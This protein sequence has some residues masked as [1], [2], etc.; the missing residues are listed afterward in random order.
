MNKLLWI[1]LAILALNCN[2]SIQKFSRD[3]N[4]NNKWEDYYKKLSMYIEREEFH[5][6][7]DIRH[8]FIELSFEIDEGKGLYSSRAFTL[9]SL[10]Y[11]QR[12]NI[13]QA[14]RYLESAIEI[15]TDVSNQSEEMSKLFGELAELYK[16]NGDYELSLNNYKKSINILEKGKG[17]L[18]NLANLYQE[19]G[20]MHFYLG[21][22]SETINYAQK[23]VYYF[24][25]L[26]ENNTSNLIN[27]YELISSAYFYNNLY[28]ESIKYLEKTIDLVKNDLFDL[29]MVYYRIGL[30]Y[31]ESKNYQQAL[32]Y[33]SKSEDLFKELNDTHE[34][35]KL[36]SKIASIYQIIGKYDRA[37]EILNT[38]FS[39]QNQSQNN[40]TIDFAELN[41]KKSQIYQ[42]K[43]QI[44]NAFHSLRETIRLDK[45]VFGEISSRVSEDYCEL[46]N[47]YQEH[48]DFNKADEHY[49]KSIDIYTKIEETDDDDHFIDCLYSY[50]KLAKKQNKVNHEIELLQ[51][52]V[53]HITHRTKKYSLDR[54]LFLKK[55]NSIIYDLIQLYT[56]KK[57][58]SNAFQIIEL[59]RDL[60]LSDHL[61]MKNLMVLS[62]IPREE[63]N[64]YIYKYNKWLS[65]QY[66]K[67][68]RS[69][70]KNLLETIKFNS[71]NRDTII[72]GELFNLKNFIESKEKMLTEKY[73][74]FRNYLRSRN[75]TIVEIQKH[76]SS[77]TLYLEFSLNN[78]DGEEYFQAFAIYQSEYKSTFIKTD[79]QLMAKIY[80]IFK[81]YS[82]VED[83][84][85]FF[86]LKDYPDQFLLARLDE[87]DKDQK[88]CNIKYNSTKNGITI[89][90]EKVL[91][92]V[93]G[94]ANQKKIK[95]IIINDQKYLF[96]IL[97]K[98]YIKKG[99][100][101]I[102]ISPDSELNLLP[103]NVLMNENGKEII[104]DYTVTMVFSGYVWTELNKLPDY[105]F[106]K[107][108]LAIGNAIYE[109]DNYDRNKKWATLEDQGPCTGE[110]DL[111]NLP[112]TEL[113]I[114]S[115][116]SI[117]QKNRT[118]NGLEA[119]KDEILKILQEQNNKYRIIH[120]A[121]HGI[122]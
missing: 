33:F 92:K 85:R 110:N 45:E 79:H 64:Q 13:P 93:S 102:I 90:E 117:F 114:E 105:S 109:S 112:S 16:L 95:E 70:D 14:I 12:K 17:N 55:Y 26:K 122:Y 84:R 63:I 20:T 31:L 60:N 47:L 83:N 94:I 104:D 36:L 80:N 103:F 29:A 101:K 81:Y 97:I 42:S 62:E 6:A 88:I 48:N 82:K 34:Q 3:E 108:L 106:S 59:V 57:L 100:R 113:E 58:M 68:L 35:I 78:R 87:C 53:D 37:L 51:K 39:L 4:K 76:L 52:A 71:N 119:N 18:F 21:L 73:P 98:P 44:E 56:D 38:S 49:S 8:A 72:N 67:R 15:N 116:T 77:D 32:V 75:N 2:L 28:E 11:K 41:R 40:S 25:E 69:K 115:I 91:E 5:S 19:I 111:K 107:D 7:D 9:L 27:L 86:I 1:L 118:L 22:F 30:V 120:F 50:S 46:G 54:Y 23:S 65:L 74:K 121:T 61:K 89:V 10:L 66:E 24:A 99:I 96:Q 43:G